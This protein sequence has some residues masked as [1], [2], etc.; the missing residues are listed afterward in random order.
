MKFTA[1][2]FKF[3]ASFHF[4]SLEEVSKLF[5]LI[6]NTKLSDWLEKAD[7]FSSGKSPSRERLRQMKLKCRRMHKELAVYEKLLDEAPVIYG[8]VPNHPRWIYDMN[9]R[10]VYDASCTHV[11]KLVCIQEILGEAN[12]L[13]LLK[14]L[15]K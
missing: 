6:A 13:E 8:S 12:R 5:A 14:G 10:G 9:F 7:R 15:R 2:D 11:A 1:E 4:K 3:S